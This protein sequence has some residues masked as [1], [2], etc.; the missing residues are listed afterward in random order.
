MSNQ[1]GIA[2]TCSGAVAH[3]DICHGRLCDLDTMDRIRVITASSFMRESGP[4]IAHQGK[5]FMA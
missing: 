3:L 5:P 2:V 4:S 1:C